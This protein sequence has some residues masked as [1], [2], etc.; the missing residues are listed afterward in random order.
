MKIEGLRI[1]SK[2]YLPLDFSYEI[3][4]K[5]LYVNLIERS[6]KE[7]IMNDQI[8][9]D[10]NLAAVVTLT[11]APSVAPGDLDVVL[12]VKPTDFEV[13]GFVTIDDEAK[14]VAEDVK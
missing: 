4:D 3:K 7:K 10:K 13:V 1:T 6:K 2:E 9:E 8:Q 14:E 12:A 11:D 5:I